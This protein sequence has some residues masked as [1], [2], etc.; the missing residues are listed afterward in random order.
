[1]TIGQIAKAVGVAQSAIRY[2]ETAGIFPPPPRKNGLR[3][4]GPEMVDQLK[5]LQFYRAS[6]VSIRSLASIAA[7]KQDEAR[8]ARR[9]TVQKRIADLDVCIADAKRAKRRL[10]QLLA[11]QCGGTRSKCVIFQ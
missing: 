2:Y 1:M 7:S 4:Y 10:E 6:G 5:V 9:A 11:C 8:H 3:C